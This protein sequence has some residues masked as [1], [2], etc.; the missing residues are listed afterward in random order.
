MGKN[1]TA[2]NPSDIPK[3]ADQRA[4]FAA[5][6]G[7]GYLDNAL[8]YKPLFHQN[9]GEIKPRSF[10]GKS[11]FYKSIYKRPYYNDEREV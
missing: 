3:D 11:V 10:S 2:E 8:E 7:L 6:K 9:A 5:L 4:A 1:F